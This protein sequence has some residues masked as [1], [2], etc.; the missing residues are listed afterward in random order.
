MGIIFAI[1]AALFTAAAAVVMKASYKSAPPAFAFLTQTI[2]CLLIMTPFA[3]LIGGKT[4]D[5]ITVFPY[6][7]ISAVLGQALYF[8]VISKGEVSLTGTILASYGIYT[9]FFSYFINHERL[10]PIQ[11]LLIAL[12]IVGTVIISLPEKISKNDFKKQSFVLWAIIGAVGIGFS[13]TLTKTVINQTST[14]SFL[15]GL[16]IANIPVT[17][18]FLL[19]QKVS[20]KTMKD[21]LTN[22]NQ[23]KAT[24][25][26]GLLVTFTLI[27]LF[28]SFE[29]TLASIAGPISGSYPAAMV[30]MAVYFLKEKLLK[31]DIVGIVIIIIGVIGI[32]FFA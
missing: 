1:L 2:F 13:D 19:L 21:F 23:Y 32:G 3:F 15:L 27:F 26:S 16:V 5:L 31:K 10:L 22:I 20:L 30:L 9:I 14:G 24:V 6:A 17:I 4:A 12:T 8:Y 18:V 7:L 28:W 11:A 25:F 29:K